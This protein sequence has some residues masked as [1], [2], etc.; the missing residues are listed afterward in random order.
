MSHS[1][2]HAANPTSGRNPEWAGRRPAPFP[3]RIGDQRPGRVPSG[4][5]GNPLSADDID[6]EI[7]SYFARGLV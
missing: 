5:P 3:E 1:N 4:A 6:E 7:R 2:D